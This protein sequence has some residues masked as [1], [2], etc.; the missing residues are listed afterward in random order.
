MTNRRY[1]A[2]LRE[3][4][5]LFDAGTIGSLTD[6]QLL[7]RFVEG[8]AE[9]GE[10]A[11]VALL[12]RHGPMVLRVCRGALRDP[13]NVEDAFQATFL[14]LARKAGS[15][16]VRDSIG[17]WL[18]G[19][20]YRVATRARSDSARR[21]RHERRAA[22]R[23]PSA[24]ATGAEVDGRDDLGPVLHEEI[25]RLPERYRA[26][27]VLCYLEGL[28]HEQAAHRLDWP[29]GT[30][31]SRLARGRDRLRDRLDRRGAVP[32]AGLLA[33][34]P[35]LRG[36]AVPRALINSTVHA[37]ARFAAGGTGPAAAVLAGGVL[38]TLSLIALGKVAVPAL[39][40]GLFAVAS[41]FAHWREEGR[42]TSRASVARGTPPPASTPAGR[43][44]SE[45]ERIAERVLK[46]GS[47]LF[48]AK[49]AGP[50]AATYAED[51]EISLTVKKEEGYRNE[52]TRGRADVERFYR[53]LF[54]GAG[55]IDSENTVEFARL[56]MP[57]LLI[58]HGRFRPN[59]GEEELPFVQ[60]RVKR[61]D[62]WQI[63]KLSLFPAHA[64]Q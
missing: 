10:L 61:D 33:A 56:V 53:D 35:S 52:V 5:T 32:S 2:A 27:I 63:L 29:V 11:F 13:N 6:G 47:D 3:V 25:R 16:W 37:A 12:E 42:G 21:R 30:V 28:T 18:H 41:G 45:A 24:S 36:P 38:R 44:S 49:Q 48:D 7:E 19:V 15:L 43:P 46:V 62:R 51:G 34:G 20:A 26:P 60:V 31:R 40:V 54:K 1:G 14:V 39:L 17:P 22:E 50:L 64:A 4:R 59:V 58:I 8:R 55:T 23:C 9:V 57:D